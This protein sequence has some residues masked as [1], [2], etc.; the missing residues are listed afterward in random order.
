MAVCDDESVPRRGLGDDSSPRP[1]RIVQVSAHYPPNFVSG[2]TLVPQRLARSVAEAGHES[3]VYAGYLDPER[4]PLETWNDRDGDVTVR[5][6]VT[7]PWTVWSHSRNSHNP[8]VDR[9]LARWLEEVAPDIVHLHSLQ[10]LGAS[11]VSTARES[12]AKVIVTMHDFWWFCARQFLLSKDLRPCSLVVDCGACPCE[13]DH[14]W[15]TSRNTDLAV[16][17]ASADVILAP[18]ES[19]ARVLRANGIPEGKLRVDENGLSLEAAGVTERR[20]SESTEEDGPLRLMY[21]GGSEPAKG[22]RVLIDAARKLASHDGWVLDMYGVEESAALDLPAQVRPQPP[23]EHRSSREILSGHDVLVLPSLMRESHSILT[24]EALSAGLAVVCTD[25]LGPEEAVEHGWNGL[26]VPAGD[27]DALA[28]ALR[29]L[30]ENPSSTI[31]LMGNGSAS[32]I[33]SLE[34]QTSGMIELY[35]QLLDFEG[36]DLQVSFGVDVS[37]VR[38]VVFIVGIQGAPLRYRAHL[39]AEALRMLGVAVEVRHYRDPDLPFLVAGTDSVVLYRVPATVQVLNLIA[40]MRRSRPDVPILFDVDD[41]IF[42]PEL[43]NEVHGLSALSADERAL[44]WRGVARYRT[45]MEAS[46]MFVG[47]T[48][49]LCRHATAVTGLPSARFANGVGTL[50]GQASDDALR[51]PRS[52]GPLRI[53][54]FSGT[55]T[56]DADWASIEPAVIDV[57]SGTDVELWLGGHL[58]P[59]DALEPFAN[60]VKRMPF[61]PWHELPRLLRDVDVCVAPLTA[62][63]RFNEAKS[64]IKWL[65]AALVET[66]VVA[67]PTQPFREAIEDGRTGYLADSHEQWVS[68]ITTLL[69]D[70]AVRR[71][72][73]TQARREALLRWSPHLQGRAYL[74]ILTTARSYVAE[75]ARRVPGE[76]TPVVDDE[77]YSRLEAY[78]DPYERPGRRR[79]VGTTLLRHPFVRKIAAA[80]RVLR[81]EGPAQVARKAAKV[82]RRS[83]LR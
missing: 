21:A 16:H 57:M 35:S 61:V 11:L 14:G 73:G 20:S 65:E 12:G 80:W 6:I 3:Y 64:A 72:I 71:R 76:W 81:A 5:W 30:I 75:S 40:D 83:F 31:E 28:G 53:G 32:P 33:R 52:S 1:L 17:L 15:L 48:E 26:V 77:P 8:D 19:A 38:H 62:N 51:Q 42:D 58:E 63:S 22:A 69:E 23:Y 4:S 70:V 7:T 82:L 60:R 27:V 50:L 59:T 24:R 29:Q 47:S 67:S 34:D 10:T 45:T 79:R 13:I 18:S 66:P 68:A 49:E 36:D 2:G 55:T 54:Y 43:E 44:W 78:V 41:L 39:P 74:D 46:D 37:P 25:T 56:H 9:D